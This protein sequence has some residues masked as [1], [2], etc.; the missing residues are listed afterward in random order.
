MSVCVRVRTEKKITPKEIFD[1]LVKR[2]EEIMVTSQEFPCLKL[3]THLLALRGIEVNEQENGYEIRVCS[4]ANEADLL[5]FGVAVS[6]I[7]EM[8]G[9]K[10]LYEDD[11]NEVIDDPKDYFGKEWIEQQQNSCIR[12]NC[13]LIRHYGKPIIMD[14]LFF[15][16]CF[17]PIMASSFKVDLAN[18]RIENLQEIQ[19]YLSGVQWRYMDK[20]STATRMALPDPKDKEAR[21]LT[22]SLIYAE[23]G[24]I[25]PFDYVSYADVVCLMDKDNEVVMVKMED[26]W[27]ILS[28]EGFIFM[29]DYQYAKEGELSYKDFLEMQKKAS[30]YQVEDLFFHP[31]YPGNGYDKKQKTYVLMW[32]PSIS[33]VKMEDHVDSIPN[34]LMEDYNWSVYEYKEAKKGDRFVMV[35]CGEGKT[36]IVMSGIFD[37]NP[38]QAGDWSGRGR[39]VFYMDMEPNFIVDPENA[40][41]ITTA[42]LRREIPSFDWG[43]GHS[44]RL[45]T[46]EQARKLDIMLADYL[47]KF[48]NNID[49]KTVNGYSLPEGDYFSD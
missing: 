15:P 28:G 49:G 18:P 2:G 29:D 32:N 6:V 17:G 22:L 36:G 35:R 45:L 7:S 43:G 12:V 3:G 16:F 31:S 21:P 4:F 24:K 27:K 26:F 46:E 41:I 14:G 19:K 47:E 10:A 23:D 8:V 20:E 5:L 38:Y 42:D 37:S 1:N 30:L 9:A 39:K 44:G 33:S 40:E 48:N 25:K 34:L 13:A 11:E